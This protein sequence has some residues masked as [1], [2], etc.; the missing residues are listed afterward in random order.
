MIKDLILPLTA[1]QG[2]SNAIEAAL[3]LATMAQTH[4]VV[5]DTVYMPAPIPGAWSVAP[6]ASSMQQV[7][8][9]VR[10]MAEAQAAR[11]RDRLGREAVSSEVR[12]AETVVGGPRHVAALHARY[13][14]LAVL[15]S[16][17]DN[18][19]ERSAVSAIFSGLLFE[20]GRPV[21]IVPPKC[22]GSF[23]A[24][25]VVVAWRPTREATRAVHDAMPWLQMADS[26]DVLEVEPDPDQRSDDG[27]LPGADI[28]THLARHGIKVRVVIHQ[29]RNE[30]VSTALLRHCEQSNATLLVAGGYGH[31]RFR[32]W[33]LGGTTREL[34]QFAHLP[35]LFSH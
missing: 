15:T 3:A 8:T 31:S 35:V 28:A 5:L 32:E 26:V 9:E 17:G 33:V 6:D 21:M 4:L 23:P 1:T 24:R 29:Q 16:A 34:L 22:T 18:A 14:D 30:S 12:L 20:S 11:L 19:G 7:Y 13:A 10:A 27:A 2:D 25:H